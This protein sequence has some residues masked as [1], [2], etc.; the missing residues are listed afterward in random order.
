MKQGPSHPAP[1]P[2]FYCAEDSRQMNTRKY[3]HDLAWPYCMAW[4]CMAVLHG[5]GMHGRSGMAS[6]GRASICIVSVYRCAKGL[7]VCKAVYSTAHC[8][9]L[10][11]VCVC[12]CR[13]FTG[14]TLI[15]ARR[16]SRGPE[17][18][19]TAEPYGLYLVMSSFVI[20][21]S[22]DYC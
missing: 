20:L 21:V 13:S 2:V 5:L 18:K 11:A 14:K 16:C 9:T 8:C 17:V 22:H 15:Y 3:A 12:V 4:A 7:K 1:L 6:P 10:W 19:H